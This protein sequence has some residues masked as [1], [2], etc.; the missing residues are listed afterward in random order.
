VSLQK[1]P[2]VDVNFFLD[3]VPEML[4]D[5][6]QLNYFASMFALYLDGVLSQCEFFSLIQDMVDLPAQEEQ[7]KQLQTMLA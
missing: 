3:R 1:F 4:K 7:F 2:K 5:R 6:T